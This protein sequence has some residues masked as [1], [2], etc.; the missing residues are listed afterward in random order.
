MILRNTEIQA[1]PARLQSAV[2]DEDEGTYAT[3]SGRG[4]EPTMLQT[5]H[6]E[7]IINIQTQLDK[8]AYLI[9]YGAF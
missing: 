5:P 4:T 6:C 8:Q 7:E 9:K 1:Q 3:K 2:E